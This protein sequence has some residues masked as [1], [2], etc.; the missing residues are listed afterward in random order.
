MEAPGRQEFLP[1]YSLLIPK[2]PEQQWAWNMW[3][4]EYLFKHMHAQQTYASDASIW[5]WSIFNFTSLLMDFH[6][7]KI[8]VMIEILK[9]REE[10]FSLYLTQTFSERQFRIDLYLERVYYIHIIKRDMSLFQISSSLCPS[11]KP[12]LW[13][14]TLESNCLKGSTADAILRMKG[15][16]TE[17]GQ[18]SQARK[19]GGIN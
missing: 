4:K 19:R 16:A 7:N 6:Q 8:M 5:K 15:R 14:L 9:F 10:Y 17:T 13:V 18:H 2:S 1:V 3:M 12:L 11:R